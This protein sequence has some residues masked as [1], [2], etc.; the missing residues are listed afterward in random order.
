MSEMVTARAVR[1]QALVFLSLVLA[2]LFSFVTVP[3]ITLENLGDQFR[4]RKGLVRAFTTFRFT[5]GDRVFNNTLVG[6]DGW[7]YYAGDWSLREYQ[8]TDRFGPGD[9]RTF[10]VNL[11]RLNSALVAQ[12]R[13]FLLVIPPNKT[14]IYPQYM[15]DEIPVIGQTSRTDQFL[16]YMRSHSSTP[17]LDLR[18]ALLAVS[19]TQQTYYRTDSHWNDLGGYYGYYE[20]LKVLSRQYPMLHPHPLSDY[21]LQVLPIPQTDLPRLMGYL[22]IPENDPVLEPRFPFMTTTVTTTLADGYQMRVTTNQ[23]SDLP[24]LLVFG[25]SFYEALEKF[26][27]PDFARVADLPYYDAAGTSLEY[28]VQQEKPDIVILECVERDLGDLFPLLQGIQP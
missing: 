11:D 16:Q 22:S 3:G 28:W 25:D 26:L 5:V 7:L 8:R 6:K 1:T 13:T 18:P 15:P 24:R 2:L 21:N 23:R 10:Q 17:I 12:G 14:S 9:L 20:I 19:A 4:W 27:K